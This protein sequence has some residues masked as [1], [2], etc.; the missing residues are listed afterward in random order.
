MPIAF[1]N[2]QDYAMVVKIFGNLV[3]GEAR[4]SPPEI[5]DLHITPITGTP[6]PDRAC[7]SHVERSNLTVRMGI[8]RFTR[9]TNGFS[10][11]P[12]HHRV[13]IALFFAYY[14]FCRVHMTLGCTPA[15]MAGLT[16]HVWD[17]QE[18]IE[19]TA[20]FDTM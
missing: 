16:D 17:V 10:K 14:N 7:T 2:L 9:L 19:K 12:R 1:G 5:I 4:Y 6:D 20:G 15:M 8:R 13:A 11:M 3:E 18:L